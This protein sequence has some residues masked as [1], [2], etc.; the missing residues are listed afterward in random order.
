M[1]EEIQKL[2]ELQGIDDEAVRVKNAMA[3]C[4]QR[5]ADAEEKL[6]YVAGHLAQQK[7]AKAE[8]EK[9]QRELSSEASDIRAL[10]KKS[11]ERLNNI[12]N[13]REFKALQ[14][15]VA[16]G[17][18]RLS[19]IDDELMAC[20]EKLEELDKVIGSLSDEEAALAEALAQEKEAAAAV[21]ADS[22]A[23]LG[24]LSS[25]RADVSGRLDPD[26]FIRYQLILKAAGG[27]A[28]V[29]V[30]NAV[31]RGCNMNIPPQAYNELQR[32]EDLRQC[33]HCERIIY[34]KAE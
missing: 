22:E 25:A 34:W 20:M 32:G 23:R 8:L 16:D 4:R 29:A 9:S 28:V 12:K 13:S 17:K 14:K 15:E 21:L 2:V 11:Q 5:V 24:E 18:R 3:Q 31:C 7:E 33:P 1:K 10:S 19:E 6:A 27:I 30:Q 26:L